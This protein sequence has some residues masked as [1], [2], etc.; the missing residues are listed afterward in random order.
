[1]IGYSSERLNEREPEHV[2]PLSHAHKRDGDVFKTAGLRV[3]SLPLSL[4]YVH[5][6]AD[7]RGK[8]AQRK[9]GIGV[10][11]KRLLQPTDYHQS[12]RSTSIATASRGISLFFFLLTLTESICH[13]NEEILCAVLNSGWIEERRRVGSRARPVH[14]PALRWC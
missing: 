1:M 5:P 12:C 10:F 14:A 7:K 8:L 6:K 9:A 2:R 11:K 3:G 4:F 13:I